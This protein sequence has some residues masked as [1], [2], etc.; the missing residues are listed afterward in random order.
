MGHPDLLDSLPWCWAGLLCPHP[1]LLKAPGLAP[2]SALSSVCPPPSRDPSGNLDKINATPG[3]G[4]TSSRRAGNGQVKPGNAEGTGRGLGPNCGMGANKQVRRAGGEFGGTGGV[5]GPCW[6]LRSSQLEWSINARAARTSMC[7][8]LP[9]PPP[10]RG[11][12]QPGGQPQP[13]EVEFIPQGP[14]TQTV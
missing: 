6:V 7:S 5:E 12:G 8:L 13:Q 11:P 14:Q 4:R 10:C 9:S 2:Q 3:S 1:H